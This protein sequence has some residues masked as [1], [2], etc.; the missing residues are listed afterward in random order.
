MTRIHRFVARRPALMAVLAAA[1]LVAACGN[2]SG[3]GY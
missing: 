1:M 3:R 2:G